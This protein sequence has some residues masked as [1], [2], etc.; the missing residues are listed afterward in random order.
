VFIETG[1]VL[2]AGWLLGVLGAI[3]LLMAVKVTLMDPNAFALATFDPIAIRYTVPV[4]IAIAV[5]GSF[6]VWARFRRFD[7]VGVVERRLV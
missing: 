4:P 1:W 2:V 3:G 5:I 6:T 7:P